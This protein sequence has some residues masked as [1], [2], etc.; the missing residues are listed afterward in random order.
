[1]EREIKEMPHGHLKLLLFKEFIRRTHADIEA[2]IP[3]TH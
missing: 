1:M 2:S 3:P